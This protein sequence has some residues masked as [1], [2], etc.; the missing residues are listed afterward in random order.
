M[1]AGDLD[2]LKGLQEKRSFVNKIL[3]KIQKRIKLRAGL[4]TAMIT[5]LTCGVL[6]SL[7]TL[8]LPA[9][10]AFIGFTGVCASL[11]SLLGCTI[12]RFSLPAKDDAEKEILLK[13]FPE[14]AKILEGAESHL[15]F[16]I[17]ARD[18]ATFI[19]NELDKEINKLTRNIPYGMI[20][21]SR[22]L[23]YSDKF[24]HVQKNNK[25]EYKYDWKYTGKGRTIE[26]NNVP[27]SRIDEES[28]DL[29]R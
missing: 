27:S 19:N 29:D 5:S 23:S 17:N 1:R 9:S 6:C 14:E 28:E 22:S 26:Q 12:T 3:S 18:C 21:E 8:A 24:M 10:L 25:K 11:G 15:K 7:I 20:D 13:N 2:R 16:E 4:K